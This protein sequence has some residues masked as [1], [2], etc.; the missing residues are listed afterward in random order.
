MKHILLFTLTVATLG[1]TAPAVE[2][3]VIN[4]ACLKSDR[5]AATPTLCRCIQKVANATLSR[6]ER[7][8][9]SKFF[10]DPHMAQEVRQSDRRGDEEF[11]KRYRAFGERAQ[12]TCR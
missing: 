5:S 2:A 4:R 8:K 7:R 6:S 11:W 10:R 12:T 3:G 9:A 1:W